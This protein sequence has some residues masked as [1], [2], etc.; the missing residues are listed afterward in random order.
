VQPFNLS[1]PHRIVEAANWS[2]HMGPQIK[3]WL[4]VHSMEA[5]EKGDT[6]ELVARYFARSSTQASAHFCVDRDS[7]VQCV[8][9]ELVAWHAPGL[10]TKGIGIEH[11]GYARQTRAEW[12]DSYGLAML[13]MS[14]RLCAEL[15]H[16]FAIPVEA[17][18]AAELFR[19]EPG[20]TTHAQVTRA[21]PTKGTHTDPGP[22]F[23]MR[24]F[25]D[26]IRRYRDAGSWLRGTEP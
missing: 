9:A 16:H 21:Y 14:A 11:A 1:L 4:V 10:N 17:V 13:D 24:E 2:R 25:L 3:R 15:C 12:L 22:G 26:L 23:P 7:I 18:G 6:A 19:G 5:P 8:P 20:I